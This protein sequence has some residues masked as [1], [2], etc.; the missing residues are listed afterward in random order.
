MGRWRRRKTAGDASASADAARRL[1]SF[2]PSAHPEPSGR[3]SR[4]RLQGVVVV[5][6][7]AP[8]AH[9]PLSALPSVHIS[10]CARARL[11]R[12]GGAQRGLRRAPGPHPHRVSACACMGPGEA[13][14]PPR[15]VAYA[16]AVAGTLGRPCITACI[17][18][19]FSPGVRLTGGESRLATESESIYDASCPPSRLPCLFVSLVYLSRACS[20]FRSCFRGVHRSAPYMYIRRAPRSATG[21][22]AVRIGPMYATSPT[23]VTPLRFAAAATI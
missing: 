19:A 7:L 10:V 20:L 4:P 16:R 3:F 17:A 22:S 21:D 1:A 11:S 18:R 8:V 23:P 6:A 2:A 13:F 5:G 12:R 14:L 15:S 9:R